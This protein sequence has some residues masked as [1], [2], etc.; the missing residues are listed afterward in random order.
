MFYIFC[1]KKCDFNFIITLHY[2]TLHLSFQNATPK[3]LS[4]V[5]KLPTKLPRHKLTI[6]NWQSI[7]FCKQV[8]EIQFLQKKKKGNKLS[9]YCAFYTVWLLQRKRLKFIKEHNLYI[10][11][12]QYCILLSNTKYFLRQKQ[13]LLPITGIC[14]KWKWS[15]W[16]RILLIKYFSEQSNNIHFTF[17]TPVKQ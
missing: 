5:I 11:L 8:T 2:T 12:A 7:R 10:Q 3:L 13:E 4:Q 14:R 9:Y 17:K 16:R 1:T 6:W 15:R